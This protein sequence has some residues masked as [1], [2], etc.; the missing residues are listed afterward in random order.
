M[1]RVYPIR[2]YTANLAA[3]LTVNQI[4]SQIKSINDLRG[5]S[6]QTNSIYMPRLRTQYGILASE[7]IYDGPQDL[8]DAM[9]LVIKGDLSALIT[10]APMI[11]WLLSQQQ[12]CT[13]RMLPDVIEPFSYGIAFRVGTSIAVV[14]TF[15]GKT[16]L[17]QH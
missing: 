3:V 17:M 6:V 8:A 14:D 4:S 16:C 9:N 2:R 1:F 15:S 7:L 10:D 5:K 13:V 11:E 12:G